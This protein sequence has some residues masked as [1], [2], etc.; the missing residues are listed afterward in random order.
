MLRGRE[1]ADPKDVDQCVAS[2]PRKAIGPWTVH[3]AQDGDVL[4]A[5]AASSDGWSLSLECSRA[6]G[7]QG[8][9]ANFDAD[10]PYRVTSAR[11]KTTDAEKSVEISAEQ[12]ARIRGLIRLKGLDALEDGLL[13]NEHILI[14]V[15]RNAADDYTMDFKFPGAKLSATTIRETCP[16]F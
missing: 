12:D 6:S 5:I 1:N 9:L 14:R 4:K 13:N 7:L 11:A 10:Y 8:T 15:S 3:R 16:K 2:L